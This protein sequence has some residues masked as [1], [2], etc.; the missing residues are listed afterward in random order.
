METITRNCVVCGKEL[1]IT[2]DTDGSYEGGTYFGTIKLGIGDYAVA[3]L[4]NG[5]LV[6]TIS[7]IRYFWY[8]LR[9]LKKLLLKQYEEIEYWECADCCSKPEEVCTESAFQL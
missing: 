9:D 3:E 5:E 2:V 4:K 1:E 7:W 8:T 6:R